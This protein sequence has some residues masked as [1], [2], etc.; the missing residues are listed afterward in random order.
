MSVEARLRKGLASNAEAF[1]PQVER[2]LAVVVFRRRRRRLLRQGAVVVAACSLLSVGAAVVPKLMGG[3]SG[4]GSV[5]VR[6]P[7]ESAS[8][9]Q[10]LTGGYATTVP[11]ASGIVSDKSLS[12]RWTLTLRA[13]G[14]LAVQAPAAY[15]GVLSGALFTSTSSVFRTSV[16]GQDLCSGQGVGSYRW[17]R[18]GTGLTFTVTDD[19]CP[20]RVA[21]FTS[22]TWNRVS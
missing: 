22:G 20:G 16:F 10:V 17:I 7:G 9:G 12:G 13:D 18:S 2:R 3:D 6:Q 4:R 15:R 14:T 19:R 11:A 1:R 21:I 5:E 8:A